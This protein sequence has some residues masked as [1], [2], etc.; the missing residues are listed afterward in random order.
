MKLNKTMGRVATTLVATAMLASVAVVPAFADP[1]DGAGTT[2]TTTPG[3]QGGETGTALDELVITKELDM[4]AGVV[5]TNAATFT[6]TLSG[7]DA[8][9]D[10]KITSGGTT[11]DV[12][13]GTG[14]GSSVTPEAVTFA[15][16][17]RDGANKDVVFS[18]EG[19]HFDDP[20]VYKYKI[21]E[22]KGTGADDFTNTTGDLDVYLF[23]E[24]TNGDTDG[25]CQIYAAVVAKDVTNAD[26]ATASAKTD[27][28]VNSYMM[29]A[30]GSLTV[31]KEIDG[32]MASPSDEFTFTISDLT[33]YRTY[34]VESNYTANSETVT[35]DEDGKATFTLTAGKTWTI[36][37]LTAD[38]YDVVENDNSKGY[39][40]TSVTADE[41]DTIAEKKEGQ[42]LLGATVTV[43]ENDEAG[44]TVLNT[45]NA[46]S[47]TGI[48]M[49]VAPY[50][51]LVVVAAA[52][53]FVFMRKRRED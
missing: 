21:T 53:C 39:T 9:H 19:F 23:V 17:S 34:V 10:E 48:V 14:T 50:A 7:V 49:N 32:T 44:I 33:P 3:V 22:T 41:G 46:V 5:T 24:D 43:S 40:L 15:A 37:G 36:K 35:A 6:F 51:L 38:Q 27:T 52:G 4:P 20:G 1:T 13:N 11:F 16:Q 29:D 8:D 26:K 31:T 25:G 2:S 18:L 47:P 30:T 28:V 45:R 12:K 42:K